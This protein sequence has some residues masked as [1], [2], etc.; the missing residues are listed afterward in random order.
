MSEISVRFKRP[1]MKLFRSVAAETAEPNVLVVRIQPGEG[2]ALRFQAKV[3]GTPVRLG[4]VRMAFNYADYFAS[5]AGH[6]L[7]DAALRLHDRAIRRCF[8]A[9]TWWRPAGKWSR[10]S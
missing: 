9:P 2:I 8:I 3:P 7:R 4:T 10:P 1:P 6:R 5:H